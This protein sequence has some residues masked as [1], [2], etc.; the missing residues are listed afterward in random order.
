M[1]LPPTTERRQSLSINALVETH[2]GRTS[3]PPTGD[4]TGQP[5]AYP[6]PYTEAPAG[7][8]DGVGARPD[9]KKPVATE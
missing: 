6:Y 2:D 9:D 3:R 8:T 4:A 5:G 7:A 1:W